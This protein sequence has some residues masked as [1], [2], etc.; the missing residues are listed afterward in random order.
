[1]GTKLSKTYF[2]CCNII[3][4]IN[5]KFMKGHYNYFQSIHERTQKL[6]Y[7]KHFRILGFISTSEYIFKR[8]MRKVKKF[9]A[10]RR[11]SKILTK[12][13]C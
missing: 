4:P 8:E 7:C 1:M 11:Y 3:S 13:E 12:A 2:K 5:L 10:K 9:T 6:S